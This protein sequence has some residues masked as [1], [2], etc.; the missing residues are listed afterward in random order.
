MIAV[1]YIHPEPTIVK[2]FPSPINA[3]KLT[4][5]LMKRCY[6]RYNQKEAG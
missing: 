6:E 2:R 5:S 1:Y 3:G 4:Y